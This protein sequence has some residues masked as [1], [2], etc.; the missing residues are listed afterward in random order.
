ML[1][2]ARL[3]YF[4]TRRVHNLSDFW[5]I[6]LSMFSKKSLILISSVELFEGIFVTQNKTKRFL[7]AISFANA[8]NKIWGCSNYTLPIYYTVQVSNV[9]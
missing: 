1:T 7:R 2:Q 3:E 4:T 8:Q 9:S 5:T 6:T